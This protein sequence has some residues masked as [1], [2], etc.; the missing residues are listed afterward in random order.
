MR[1][2]RFE[3]VYLSAIR[4]RLVNLVDSLD[5]ATILHVDMDAFFVSVEELFEASLKGNSV[6]VEG[7]PDTGG[8]Q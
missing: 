4:P 8:P 5:H 7:R 2:V 6:V 3:Q 1:H